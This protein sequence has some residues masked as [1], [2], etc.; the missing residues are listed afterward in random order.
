MDDVTVIV[1][2]KMWLNKMKVRTNLHT[3]NKT[4]KLLLCYHTKPEFLE[5]VRNRCENAWVYFSLEQIRFKMC[6]P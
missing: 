6:Y 1:G 4:C 2:G 3:G 5:Q